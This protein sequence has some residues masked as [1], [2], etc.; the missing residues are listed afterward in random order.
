MKTICVSC[1][2]RRIHNKKRALCLKCY[3]RLYR[4]GQLYDYPIIHSPVPALE[5]EEICLECRIKPVYSMSRRLCLNCYARLRMRG[6]LELYPKIYQP[7]LRERLIQKYGVE[8]LEDLEH[9]S[10]DTTIT[11]QVLGD[12]YGVSRERIRQFLNLLYHDAPARSENRSLLREEQKMH[13]QFLRRHPHNLD[14]DVNT[15]KGQHNRAFRIVYDKLVEFGYYPSF[16]LRGVLHILE[17][18]NLR[19]A[20]RSTDSPRNYTPHSISKYYDVPIPTKNI[21]FL[22]AYIFPTKV[23]YIFPRHVFLNTARIYINSKDRTAYH[24]PTKYIEYR[25]A[26][27]LLWNAIKKEE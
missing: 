26:W 15:A 5:P 22:I 24:T 6:T 20:V 8:I 2:K 18:E 23:C 27:H 13:E 7:S 14:V 21:D 9:Y 4:N 17:L 25:E 12:K 19:I 1:N 16:S 3:A 10:T 11:L